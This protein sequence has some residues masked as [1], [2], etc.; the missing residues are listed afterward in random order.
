MVPEVPLSHCE[1][2]GL[3]KKR[4]PAPSVNIACP[5]VPAVA[6]SVKVRLDDWEEEAWSRVVKL[7][8]AI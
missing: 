4:F 2:P 5:A 6:G 8:E 1:E 7:L 3:P